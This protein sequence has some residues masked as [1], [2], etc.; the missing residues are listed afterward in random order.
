VFIILALRCSPLDIKGGCKSCLFCCC[1]KLIELSVKWHVIL[2]NPRKRKNTRKMFQV[3]A[4]R[5]ALPTT[6][7]LYVLHTHF[8]PKKSVST[9][10]SRAWSMLEHH[11]QTSRSFRDIFQAASPHHRCFFSRHGEHVCIFPVLPDSNGT[12]SASILL[13]LPPHPPC[14]IL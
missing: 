10:T 7:R 13:L 1:Y 3:G 5:R 2:S 9:P 4:V 14:G 8:M 6:C 11:F 12:L